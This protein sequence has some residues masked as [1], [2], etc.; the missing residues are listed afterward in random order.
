MAVLVVVGVA[1]SSGDD[2]DFTRNTAF[3]KGGVIAKD[4]GAEKGGDCCDETL[5]RLGQIEDRLSQIET[6]LQQA[7][8][9]VRNAQALANGPSAEEISAAIIDDYFIRRAMPNVDNEVRYLLRGIVA[10]QFLAGVPSETAREVVVGFGLGFMIDNA[11]GQ[12][13]NPI[14]NWGTRRDEMG[15]GGLIGVSTRDGLVSRVRDAYFHG[16]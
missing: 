13:L 8:P 10:G 2:T 16:E 11:D 7:L 5:Y 9:L 4:A 14:I 15:R 3:A 12:D 1:V 6:S